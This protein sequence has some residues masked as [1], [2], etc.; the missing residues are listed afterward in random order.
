MMETR[1]LGRSGLR[2][3]T[4]G[5][6][7]GPVGHAAGADADRL[8]QQTVEAAWEAG[9]RTFDTAP[10][11]GRGNSERRLGAVL[12]TKP[13]DQFVLSTKV[14]RFI[15]SGTVDE[16]VYDYSRDGAR[17][18]LEQSLE[19]LGLDRA[20]LVL[21][22]DIDR[23]THGENQ[24]ARF[25]EA[26]DGA[27]RALTDLKAAGT[28]GAIGI[29]VN[30]WQ[31]CDAF[32]RRAPI[33]CVLLAG[34]HTILERDAAEYFLPYCTAASIGVIVGGPFNS[35]ILATG[36]VA[37]AT[38]N[39]GPVPP[40]LAGRVGRIEAICLSHGV[41]LAAAALAYPLLH[42]AVATVIPGM[43]SA[44]EV[45]E[46]TAWARLPV[47]PELWDALRDADLLRN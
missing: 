40:L 5:F 39:Y 43:A 17:I 3:T 21:I 13:R 34:R 45:F 18:A 19:R 2:L 38:Y 7:G 44:A 22:H 9:I 30:E 35:G 37:G 14:A 8:A 15:R 11:Y 23:W 4:L 24:P 27:Y 41:P 1:L 20:D 31:V 25:A 10:L 26:L 36:A 12:C 29:G 16:L 32:A 33:D 46:T 6:G 42:P 28:V 47:P